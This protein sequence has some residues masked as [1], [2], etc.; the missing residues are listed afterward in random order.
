[1]VINQVEQKHFY[2][3]VNN[4]CL[5]TRSSIFR[6]EEIFVDFLLLPG[7]LIGLF[8]IFWTTVCELVFYLL[9]LK[10]SFSSC[11]QKNINQ[12]NKFKSQ[13]NPSILKCYIAKTL[14]RSIVVTVVVWALCKFSSIIIIECIKILKPS[15]VS[16]LGMFFFIWNTINTYNLIPFSQP[17]KNAEKAVWRS[18]FL[19]I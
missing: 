14:I 7:I 11:A 17:E 2:R 1:M 12:N 4:C 10:I 5:T 19:C 15:S 18:V 6:A 16:H 8:L 9:L 3:F 13:L